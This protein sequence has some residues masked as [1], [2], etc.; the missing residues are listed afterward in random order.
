M[1]TELG[2]GTWGLSG[3]GY[4]PVEPETREKVLDRAI[5][6]G[7][8]LFDV[9]NA[10]G[11]SETEALLG[12][13][14]QRLP[15]AVVVTR[16]GIDRSVEPPKRDFSAEHIR[17][18]VERSMRRLRR[19]R[20]DVL[21]LSGPG[22]ETLDQLS[23]METLKQLKKEGKVRA[24]GISA[25]DS[26]IARRAIEQGAEVVSLPYNLLHNIDLHRI[27]GEALVYGTGILAHSVL[28]YGMLA[29]AWDADKT[30]EEHDHRSQRWSKGEFKERL[31]HVDALRFLVNDRVRSLR[32]AAVRY[33]LSNHQVHSAILG[34]RTPLQ[35]QELVLEKGGGP[36]YL[37]DTDLIQIPRT[38][39]RLGM[40]V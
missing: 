24:F 16:I 3:D 39:T 5:E 6:M 12:K 33:V 25:G 4:G 17:S 28:A 32:G 14:V 7:I 9:S 35:L 40:M 21:L 13:R 37:S 11:G 22:H 15:D 8:R 29:G 36:V 27:S 31:R 18:S 1:V 38:L 26:E 34:P 2:L 19:D 30:F 23:V 10:Y 20:L